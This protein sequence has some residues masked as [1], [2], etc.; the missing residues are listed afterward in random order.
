MEINNLK[1]FINNYELNN[2]ISA[3]HFI[4]KILI[5]FTNNNYLIKDLYRSWDTNEI[6]FNLT[7]YHK[8]IYIK[9]FKDKNE[10]IIHIKNILSIHP[11]KSDKS[12]ELH[13]LYNYLNN[14]NNNKY[15][16]IKNI[17]DITNFINNN[18]Y[19]DNYIQKIK[20]YL[21]LIKNY[22]YCLGKLDTKQYQIYTIT[23]ENKKRIIYDLNYIR[24][25]ISNNQRINKQYFD[26][27][28]KKINITKN[29]WD[30]YFNS[31][32][33]YDYKQ[34]QEY[35]DGFNTN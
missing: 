23:E 32:I 19:N 12:S 33:I 28:L 17:N 14:N 3:S 30:I 35:K 31:D 24:Y 16:N 34:S 1:E 11:L 8:T 5:Y 10:L 20:N 22:Y 18:I 15:I 4:I 26:I 25:K 2:H 13:I 21:K 29:E 27:L 9:N 7:C 6:M